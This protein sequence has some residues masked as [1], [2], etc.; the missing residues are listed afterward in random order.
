MAMSG[1]PM[2][3]VALHDHSFRPQDIAEVLMGKL[4]TAALK[5]HAVRHECWS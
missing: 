4:A 5:K 2:Q 3:R 1:R